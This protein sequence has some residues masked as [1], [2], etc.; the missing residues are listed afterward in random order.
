MLSTMVASREEACVM[1]APEQQQQQQQWN[2][3]EAIVCYVLL[4][5]S[6]SGMQRQHAV[7]HL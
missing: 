7:P 4:Q 1:S 6:A 5:G 2:R 3:A